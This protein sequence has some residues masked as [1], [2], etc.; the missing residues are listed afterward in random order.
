MYED[1]YQR[2]PPGYMPQ[3]QYLQSSSEQSADYQMLL[4][5]SKLGVD[6]YAAKRNIDLNCEITKQKT[7]TEEIGKR[8][9]AEQKRK[10]CEKHILP[11]VYRAT[12]GSI[13]IAYQEN[14]KRIVSD[15][16]ILTDTLAF[17]IFTTR[18]EQLMKISWSR[19]AEKKEITVDWGGDCFKKFY[20]ALVEAGLSFLRC[21]HEE[22]KAVFFD[23]ALRDAKM[24]EVPERWGWNELINGDLV[25][26]N[27]SD[28]MED[29]KYEY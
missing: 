18:Y 20:R 16:L 19:G 3:Q 24:H 13:M 6:E 7:I 1:Y 14:G 17:E 9:D 11:T 2:Q 25:F 26:C 8:A 5:K 28:N 15:Q 29:M 27:S 22:I 23:F 21:M 4:M 12:N 10:L